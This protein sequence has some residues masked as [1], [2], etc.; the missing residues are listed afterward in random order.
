MVM[1]TRV[2]GNKWGNCNSGKSD[3]NK[4][5]RQATAMRVL[6]MATTI[7]WVMMMAMR[8]VG[9]NEGNGKSGK[10]YGNGNGN[11]GGGQ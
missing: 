2:V 5:G 11:E 8:V 10:D 7:T 4:G 3:S 9:N 6:V 1:A